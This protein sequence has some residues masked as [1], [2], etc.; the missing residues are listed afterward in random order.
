MD[1]SQVIYNLCPFKIYTEWL[2]SFEVILFI[3]RTIIQTYYTN[4]TANIYH[5]NAYHTFVDN[6]PEYTLL[7][8]LDKECRQFIHTHFPLNVLQTYDTLIA[9]AF[10]ADLFRYCYLYVM[11]GCYFDNK[12]INRQPLRHVINPEDSLLVCSDT[13]PN[14]IF[15]NK[16]SET[17]KLYNAM[18]CVTPHE[19]HFHDIIT[20]IVHKVKGRS[21]WGGDLALTGPVAFYNAIH[22]KI[23]ETQLRFKH[24]IN[25][26]KTLT[27][28][29]TIIQ[30]IPF[31]HTSH[32]IASSQER[33]Y[34][35]YIVKEKVHNTVFL[36]KYYQNYVKGHGKSYSELWQLGLIYYDTPIAYNNLLYLYPYPN[37]LNYYS[38]SFQD[39]QHI[40]IQKLYRMNEFDTAFDFIRSIIGESDPD[41]HFKLVNDVTSDEY[42]V[43]IERREVDKTQRSGSHFVYRLPVPD[44]AVMK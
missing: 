31:T 15:A 38:V 4:K 17:T 29:E 43:V 13:L 10:R 21:T 32:H 33:T 30:L 1:T 41:L 18:I 2:A 3:P 20:F 25:H 35:D 24:G 9:T 7:F 19:S 40:V 26:M 36:T 12:M 8:M 11:G 27:I 37:I 23:T 34:R 39:E 22:T 5:Y 44:T 42:N 28:F 6:N 14:G 16:L